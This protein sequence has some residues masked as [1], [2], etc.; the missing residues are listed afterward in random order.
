[1]TTPSTPM[2]IQNSDGASRHTRDVEPTSPSIFQ[3]IKRQRAVTQAFLG[4]HLDDP[5]RDYMVRQLVIS[6]S[7]N[8]LD[9][10]AIVCWDTS[11]VLAKSEQECVAG[12]LEREASVPFARTA[13]QVTFPLEREG[14]MIFEAT[15]L[16][17]AL[18]DKAWAMLSVSAPF[19]G[20]SRRLWGREYG[21]LSLGVLEV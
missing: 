9:E 10:F 21:P 17:G 12:L 7:A 13:A 8:T 20:S 4:K 15:V 2:R 16:C 18:F 19:P 1:M 3:Y 14:R 6:K 11:N 5:D